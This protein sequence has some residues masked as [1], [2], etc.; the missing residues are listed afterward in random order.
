MDPFSDARII[1]SWH[2]NVEA[3]TVAVRERQIES[4]QLVTDQAIVDAILDRAQ[5][6]VLDIG[7]GEGWLARALSAQS[8]RVTGIDAVP[9]LI[10]QAESEGGGEFQVLAYEQIATGA[11]DS[12]AD[13]VVC[14]FALLGRESVEGLFAAVPSLLNSGGTFIVQ[15]LHPVSACGELPYQDGWREGSWQ[16]FGSAFTDPAP[17]YFR[18]LESWTGLFT[19]SGLRLIET[20]EPRHPETGQPVSVIFIAE[21][22]RLAQTE[23]GTL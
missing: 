1:D 6:S 8:I 10:Q 21:T 9:A 15:T 2:K 23:T 12:H 18:T 20:R 16:G 17:W 22:S 14:N 13:V 19:R 5:D 3:W 11:L 7:C 4:R